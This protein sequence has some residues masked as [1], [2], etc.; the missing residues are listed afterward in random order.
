MQ[1]VHLGSGEWLGR[2]VPTS[3]PWLPITASRV[4]ANVKRFLDLWPASNLASDLLHNCPR[5]MGERP[6]LELDK[7]EIEL[8]KELDCPSDAMKRVYAQVGR[9][10]RTDLDVQIVG[11]PGVGKAT[12]ARRLHRESDYASSPFVTIQAPR[13]A[14]GWMDSAFLGTKAYAPEWAAL[15]AGGAATLFIPELTELEPNA[16]AALQHI[17][18][19]RDSH[20][21][22]TRLRVIAAT[23]SDPDEEIREGHLR[24]DLLLRLGAITIRVPA[25]RDRREDLLPLLEHFIHLASRGNGNGSGIDFPR[26]SF[27]PLLGYHW[28][29][30]VKELREL[31]EELVQSGADPACLVP[32]ERQSEQGPP[33]SEHSPAMSL[34]DAARIASEA[35]ERQLIV[36]ALEENGWNRKRASEKLHI[37]YRV[38]LDKIRRLGIR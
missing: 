10:A 24:E 21:S 7:L 15:K 2:C 14:A 9:I 26:S 32:E 29:G 1:G 8:Q 4:F 11:E 19:D 5:K 35:V 12:I 37:S 30:N 23:S 22:P 27:A 28:P 3:V 6:L 13:L 33:E 25:L 20:S 36:R 38:L 34:A 16:Q 17:L 18:T 31:S